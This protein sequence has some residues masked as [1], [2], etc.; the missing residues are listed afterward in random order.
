M[1][2]PTL[3]KL[4]TIQETLKVIAWARHYGMGKARRNEIWRSHITYN[5]RGK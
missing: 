5:R 4:D 2:R 3:T 1:I